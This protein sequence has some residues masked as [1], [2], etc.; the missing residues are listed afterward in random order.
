MKQKIEIRN[1]LLSRY[2]ISGNLCM[3]LA[4]YNA[5]TASSA[6]AAAENTTQMFI[7]FR[8]IPCPF[9]SFSLCLSWGNLAELERQQRR[10]GIS[11]SLIANVAAAGLPPSRTAWQSGRFSKRKTRED[12]YITIEKSKRLK[13]EEGKDFTSCLLIEKQERRPM[14]LL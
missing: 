5:F 1:G 13:K 7:Y 9:V 10:L 4:H 14:L 11:L 6:A 3:S 8:R 12:L 2:N